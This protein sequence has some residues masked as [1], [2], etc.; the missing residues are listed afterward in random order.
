MRCFQ[1]WKERGGGKIPFSV[2]KRNKEKLRIE[3]SNE[4]AER[5]RERS[6]EVQCK[7]EKNRTRAGK[8]CD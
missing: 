5:R 8:Q 6:E 7:A 3:G 1:Q 4:L 2:R